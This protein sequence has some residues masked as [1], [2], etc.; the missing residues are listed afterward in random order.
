MTST[1]ARDPFGGQVLAHDTM[2][3]MFNVPS[4]IVIGMFCR[5]TTAVPRLG[6]ATAVTR[7][8]FRCAFVRVWA[9]VLTSLLWP[10]SGTRGFNRVAHGGVSSQNR[11]H[12]AEMRPG[13]GV[14]Q[15]LLLVLKRVPVLAAYPPG[16]PVFGHCSYK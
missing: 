9:T 2:V 16:V 12:P 1:T 13:S 15:E 11:V 10:Q 14:R 8:R 3:G 5:T 7:L 6:V 4:D